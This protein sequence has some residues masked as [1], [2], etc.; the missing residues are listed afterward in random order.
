MK[1]RLV[2]WE[3]PSQIDGGPIVVVAARRV[4][5][6]QNSKLGDVVQTWIMRADRAPAEARQ[7]G[8]DVSIC[9]DCPLK[10]NPDEPQTRA[11][12][13][14]LGQL[15]NLWRRYRSGIPY[16][17][18]DQQLE[19][20]MAGRVVRLGSYGDPVAVPIEVWQA[21][22]SIAKATIGY[23]HL[24]RR[25]EAE[26]YRSFLM[27][28]VD[29]ESEGVTARWA[30]W[31]TFRTR[32]RTSEWVP[33][34]EPPAKGEIVCPASQEGGYRSTC[35]KCQLCDGTRGPWDIRRNIVIMAHGS[36]KAYRRLRVLR[37]DLP[38]DD[39]HRDPRA[40]RP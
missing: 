33:P 11:C 8:Q 35:E 21:I 14:H 15:G 25:P 2:L 40:L 20:M 38:H 17:A 39:P 7:R 32:P 16:L 18:S 37:E 1:D 30:G 26:P 34:I 27:A 19:A 13:V 9:G 12:Y 10:G 4:T 24:W 23:T 6:E 31:R 3:G 28:S 36:H 29:S 22:R 5:G